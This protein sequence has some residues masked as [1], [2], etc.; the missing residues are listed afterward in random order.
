[1][2]F[3]R[4]HTLQMS[5]TWLWISVWYGLILSWDWNANRWRDSCVYSCVLVALRLTGLASRMRRIVSIIMRSVKGETRPWCIRISTSQI[6][7]IFYGIMTLN[8]ASLVVIA[9]LW[10]L[11]EAIYWSLGRLLS[12]SIELAR[13][14]RGLQ[15]ASCWLVGVGYWGISTH[16][17]LGTG[18]E[19]TLLLPCISAWST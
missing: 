18:A 4:S 12:S 13:P 11:K 14:F 7:V 9:A 16:R 1:M 17:I 8:T 5:R 6:S 2:R 15:I 3:Q 19:S 10:G